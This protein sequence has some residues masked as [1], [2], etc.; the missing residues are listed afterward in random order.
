MEGN[1]A[2]SRRNTKDNNLARRIADEAL[3]TCSEVPMSYLLMAYVHSN[4]YWLGSTGS[5]RESIEKAIELV[6]KALALDGTLALAHSFLG[7]LYTQDRQYERGIAE[8]ERA[9][10]LN[11]GE[12]TILGN[13]G[14]SL[15][16]AGRS[17]EA[18]TLIQKAIRLNPFGSFPSCYNMLG[19]ALVFAGRYEEAVSAYQKYLQGTPN[20]IWAHVMLAA[21][22]SLMG[23]QKEAQAQAA[24]VL[25]INPRFSLDFWAKTALVRDQPIRDKIFNAL[26]EAGIR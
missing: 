5:P 17:E 9:V 10:A 3:A 14:F 25:T 19:N 24:E 11:P 8:G 18:I 26:Q 4:D 15:S 16:M 21:T 2:A 23:R 22:Y 6:Q 1:D 20:N 12:A 13:Y 7:F